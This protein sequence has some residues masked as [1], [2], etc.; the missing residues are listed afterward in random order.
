MTLFVWGVFGR[1]GV[2]GRHI[3]IRE[4]LYCYKKIWSCQWYNIMILATVVFIYCFKSGEG[5]NVAA[6]T[7]RYRMIQFVFLCISY[8]YPGT[9]ISLLAHPALHQYKWPPQYYW[10]LSFVITKLSNLIA[11]K[12]LKVISRIFQ[13]Q[14]Y[15]LRH[16]Y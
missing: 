1:W 2:C 16:S 15:S 10:L 12:K 8:F 14:F 6:F 4:N 9:H 3:R 7:D 5:W 13:I 11:E